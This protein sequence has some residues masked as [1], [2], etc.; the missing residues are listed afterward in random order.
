M[1]T[2]LVFYQHLFPLNHPRVTQPTLCAV[3][4][5][6]R[7]HPSYPPTMTQPKPFSS[8]HPIITPTLHD[9]PCNNLV[10]WKIALNRSARAVFV[11]W[12]RFSFLFG[13]CENAVWAVLNT[14][15]GG[16]VAGQTRFS[17]PADLQANAG[18]A[19]RDAFKCATD[20]SQLGSHVQLLSVQRS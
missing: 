17:G 2:P 19:A 10:P 5:T 14:P 7:S 4:P 9:T 1:C 16:A 11:E 8:L 18:P 15:P 12:E 6:P 20:A 3:H 13:V